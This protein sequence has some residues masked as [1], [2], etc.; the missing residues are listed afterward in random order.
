MHHQSIKTKKCQ[1]TIFL[2][3]TSFKSSVWTHIFNKTDALQNWHTMT[4]SLRLLK[5]FWIKDTRKPLFCLRLLKSCLLVLK[6]FWIKD[7]RKKLQKQCSVC[8]AFA[9]A[10]MSFLERLMSGQSL[11][12]WS[13]ALLAP[14]PRFH[15]VTYYRTICL[16]TRH[17]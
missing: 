9:D 15:A 10:N 3:Y 13:L 2:S 8:A 17:I 4:L 16:R 1:R 11:F 5:S 14:L 12:P 6:L 7:H